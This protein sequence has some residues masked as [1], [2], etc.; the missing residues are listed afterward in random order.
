MTETPDDEHSEPPVPSAR[1]QSA[2]D[3]GGRGSR[4]GRFEATPL[5]V[6]G[7]SLVSVIAG[8]VIGSISSYLTTSAQIRHENVLRLRD[9]TRAGC[10]EVVRLSRDRGE[11]IS[12]AISA[13]DGFI[14]D[15]PGRVRED[16]I[17]IAREALK[18]Y[19]ATDAEWNRAGATL[20]LSASPELE[21][22]VATF[23][24]DATEVASL[25]DSVNLPP[26]QTRNE[27]LYRVRDELSTQKG[28]GFAA[29][30]ILTRCQMDLQL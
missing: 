1:N 6:A 4:W 15:Y 12:K 17:T 22:S 16:Q 3:D 27:A 8:A 28:F 25:I 13:V 20:F 14:A 30:R 9:E 11:R 19:H 5:V 29:R 23:H 26:D 18:Q 21:E 2:V 10:I 24:D 7:V